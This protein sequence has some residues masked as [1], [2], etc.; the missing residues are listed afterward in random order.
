MKDI[1]YNGDSC[2]TLGRVHVKYTLPKGA[3]LS[4]TVATFVQNV[5]LIWIKC[6]TNVGHKCSCWLK[7]VYY[8][9]KHDNGVMQAGKEIK[10]S[11]KKVEQ[12]QT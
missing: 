7:I 4:K 5:G 6:G 9:N 10:S 12:R 8:C 2:K 11:F 1:P 3:F